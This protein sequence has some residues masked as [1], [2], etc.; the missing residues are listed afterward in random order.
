MKVSVY[1]DV[2]VNEK[3]GNSSFWSDDISSWKGRKK[4]ILHL[5]GGVK[6]VEN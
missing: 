2:F 5:F 1:I 3:N 4:R 6:Y